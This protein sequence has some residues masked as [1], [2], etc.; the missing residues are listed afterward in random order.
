MEAP[1]EALGGQRR[2]E[3]A[4]IAADHGLEIGVERR[5]RGPLELADLGKD[6]ARAGDVAI[7]PDRGGRFQ[8]RDLVSRIRIG[9]DEDDGE[10]LAAG[11]PE[12]QRGGA[13][14]IDVERLADRAIGERALIDLQPQVAVDHRD[15]IAPEAPGMAAVAAAHLQH[16]AE[17][18]G[19]DQ[20]GAGALALQQRIGADGGAMHDGREVGDGAEDT[21]APRESPPASS[22]RL[23]GTLAVRNCAGGLVHRRRDQ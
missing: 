16:V 23:D 4:E 7:G 20:P 5:G 6:L 1:A 17:A 12:L 11:L 2:V 10:R 9:V 13:D 21:S 14:L 18:A 22:P 15:E 8:R 19:G 3:L